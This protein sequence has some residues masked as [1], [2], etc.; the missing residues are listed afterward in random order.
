MGR[1]LEQPEEM[2]AG[3]AGLTGMGADVADSRGVVAHHGNR[4]ADAV[5]GAGGAG[6]VPQRGPGLLPLGELLDDGDHQLRNQRF[7]PGLCLRTAGERLGHR[8]GKTAHTGRQGDAGLLKE[9]WCATGRPVVTEPGE[10]IRLDIQRKDDRAG[11]GRIM[12]VV[13]RLPRIDQNRL[14]SGERDE[15]V[16]HHELRVGA[17]GLDQHVAVWVSMP[18]QWRVHVQQGDAPERAMGD[19]ERVGHA[20]IR[21]RSGAV[22]G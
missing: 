4:P 3:Q 16:A 17:L 15:A 13:V 9:P 12:R 18:H 8:V 19:A 1:L 14:V 22:V 7:L 5:V 10:P 21:P 6:D 11:A 20:A 2:G